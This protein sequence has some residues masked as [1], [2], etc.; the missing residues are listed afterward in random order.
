MGGKKQKQQP[1]PQPDYST[2]EKQKER[3]LEE[4]DRA[5]REKNARRNNLVRRGKSV[6][7]YTSKL[8]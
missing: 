2:I 1:L 5:R 6:L 8:G 4:A 3:E 7:S